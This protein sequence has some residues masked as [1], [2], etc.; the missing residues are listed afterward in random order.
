MLIIFFIFFS[1]FLFGYIADIIYYRLFGWLVGWSLTSLFS[2]NT[3][4]MAY[5][6]IA[7]CSNI[8]L[9]LNLSNYRWTVW[10]QHQH[11]QL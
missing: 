9:S 2:T 6:I 1:E 3:C 10:Q 7:Q 11:T 8:K 5:R 4:H